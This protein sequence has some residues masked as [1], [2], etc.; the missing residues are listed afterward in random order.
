MNIYTEHQLLIMFFLMI[1][2]FYP[3]F[4]SIKRFLLPNFNKAIE[5]KYKNFSK[6]SK[7]HNISKILLM[8]FTAFYLMFWNNLLDKSAIIHN[9]MLT[10][11]KDIGI[12]I[13]LVAT[14][15][16]SLFT[17]INIGIAVFKTRDPLKKIEVDLYAHIFQIIIGTCAALTIISLILGI[18]ITSLFTSIGAAAALL[19]FVFKDTL[20]GLLASLQLTL[21]N[22]IRV[23]DWISIPRYNVDGWVDK[24]TISVIIIRNPDQTT[25]TVPTAAFLT[26]DIKNK[27]SM[28]EKGGRRIK[29]AISLDMDTITECNQQTLDLFKKLPLLTKFAKD[30]K[31]L[32]L[33]KNNTNNLTIFRHYIDQYLK[34][35]D[36]IHQEGFMSLVR[37]LEP[38]PNGIPLEIYVFTK[39]TNLV[40]YEKTQA[41][42]FDHLLGILPKFG[43][44]AFQAKL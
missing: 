39:D 29:R 36:D 2:A 11:L 31:S 13:Y 18:D 1:V 20:L 5:L 4:Y 21:Q 12:A 27:R 35:N 44:K 43:L 37:Q 38:S 19:S 10:K 3:I 25:T 9:V 8:L 42:I 32:F 6:L 24:I 17:L 33:E 34:N 41:N 14:I 28:I 26:T 16:L 23:G 15:A 22:I 30:N 40:D 7:K